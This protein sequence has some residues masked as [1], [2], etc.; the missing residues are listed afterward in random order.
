MAGSWTHLTTSTGR[1]RE[2]PEINQNID[3]LGDAYEVFE[4]CFGMVWWLADRL[5][6]SEGHP[7]P[8]RQQILRRIRQAEKHSREGLRQGGISRRVT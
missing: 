5:V 4:D 1:L 6:R 3:T 7:N 2:S 8:S